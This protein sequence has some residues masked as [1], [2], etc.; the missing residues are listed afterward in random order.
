M[1]ANVIIHP[2]AGDGHCF[3]HAIIRSLK[4]QHMIEIDLLHIKHVIMKE[5][6]QNS[7]KYAVFI[8]QSN[9]VRL[10]VLMNNYIEFKQYNTQFGDIVP[11]ITANALN[12]GLIIVNNLE[13]SDR[14]YSVIINPDTPCTK[15]VAITRSNDHYNALAVLTYKP[16]DEHV[17]SSIPTL[18]S[19]NEC[20]IND[21]N[22]DGIVQNDNCDELTHTMRAIRA[23]HSSNLISAHININSIRNKLEN[24][25]F[26]LDEGLVDI[27]AVSESKLD[28][29]FTNAQFHRDGY[30]LHRNDRDKYGGGIMM[31]IR[32]D[33]PHRIVKELACNSPNVE[34][35]VVEAHI[36]KEKW[37][38]VTVYNPHKRYED[39]LV[40]FMGNLYEKEIGNYTDIV[41]LGDI[42]VD[43]S[44][45]NTKVSDE[46]I[47]IY[48]LHNLVTDPTC[49][50]SKQGTLLDPIIV[51]NKKRFV[52]TFNLH[53]GF[54]DFHNIVGCVT[55]CHV[56]KQCPRT[57]LY[58]SYRKFDEAA[59]KRDVSTIQTSAE[60]DDPNA[61]F[62]DYQAQIIHLCNKHAPIKKRTIK[63][64][65]VPYMNKE[66]RSA[67]YIRNNLRNKFFR[68]RSSENWELYRKQ[69]NLVT[70][71]RRKS[72]KTYFQHKCGN[73]ENSKEFWKVIK[74][75][76][77]DKNTGSASNII[78]LKEGDSI[79]SAPNEV[80]NIFNDFFSSLANNIGTSRSAIDMNNLCSLEPVYKHYSTHPSIL[81]IRDLHRHTQEFSFQEITQEHVKLKLT[82][83]NSK[84]SAGPDTIPP[85]LVKIIH[86]E[87]ACDLTEIFNSCIRQG[88][89]PE[90][91]KH[92]DITPIYKKMDA[93]SK[94]NYRPVNVIGVLSKL[95]EIIL[96]EQLG[97][98]FKDRFSIFLSAYRKKY[99]C[100]N[101]LLH[102]TESWKEALDNKMYVGAV[103]MD[104]SKA[105][106]CLPPDLFVAKLRAYNASELTCT[107]L[108]SYLT[109]RKQ[110]VKIGTERSAWSETDKGVPQ[111]SG[112][113]PLIFNIFIN[114][115]FYFIKQCS[116]LNYADDNTIYKCNHSADVVINTLKNDCKIAVKWFNENYMQAN[117]SKFQFIFLNPPN[118]QGCKESTLPIFNQ[119]IER[120][121]DVKL[122]GVTIDDRLKYREHIRILCKKAARQLNAFSRIA[123]QLDIK[124]REMVYNSF[125]SSVFNFCPLIWHFC[126]KSDYVKLEKINKRA[127]RIVY[128]DY[129]HSYEELLV[130]GNKMSL[131]KHSILAFAIETY[132]IKNGL[133]IVPVESLDKP[134]Y[135]PYNLRRKQQNVIPSVN[136]SQFGLQSF[137]YFSSHIW[138]QIPDHIKTSNNVKMFKTRLLLWNGPTCACK[139]CAHS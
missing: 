19:S 95:F 73:T 48:D 65:Q 119:I 5:V 107:L 55:K 33:I 52:H 94:D 91:M 85:K 74:P 25:T 130:L 81:A 32:S 131:R 99:S 89:F 132:K 60:C 75:F 127:L 102:M 50:K 112:L 36:R 35:L 117:P 13:G 120:S 66:L 133:S 64:H 128:N 28:D 78:S 138:N 115:I 83:L 109:K 97:S 26:L 42:N 71:T 114:D 47:G 106:D 69:R 129:E 76:M 88:I 43:L 77:T 20:I 101:A 93:L 37:L 46:V 63:Q 137:R 100:Q 108:A 123:K 53:C 84:K 27:L 30:K 54:S 44:K 125:I 98:H 124:E 56:K 21:D 92:A 2:V 70:A 118:K 80:A 12:I 31:Y 34:S 67:M 134:K 68:C 39:E 40:D 62:S 110:R 29:S 59:F 3:L 7:S 61:R 49:F 10:K 16:Y 122:L 104:L 6:N 4:C 121:S 18:D 41:C 45:E 116:I 139:Y 1:H 111:G 86:A 15:W 8:R 96:A 11:Y 135:V 105:F 136:T 24:I 82:R 17:A 38:F 23:K 22:D 14:A 90:D 87:I 58:R 79:I 126:N 103:L 72:I 57:I 51:T 113:G 9:E